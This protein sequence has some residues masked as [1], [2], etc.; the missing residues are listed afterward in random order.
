M[1]LENKNQGY[2]SIY[3]SLQDKSWYSNPDYLALWIHLLLSA[4]HKD[5]FSGDTLIKRGQLKT[6]RKQLA[7]KTGINESK[8]ERILK[9]FEESEQQIEQQKTNKFRL[10]T[11]NNFD[12][13]QNVNSKVNNTAQ[14]SNSKTTTKNTNNN[15]NKDNNSNKKDISKKESKT[16]FGYY[17]K[18]KLTNEEYDR[19]L[20]DYG[21]NLLETMIQRLDEYNEMKGDKYKSH[22]A[23]IRNW[24]KR[25]KLETKSDRKECNFCRAN[26]GYI[27]NGGQQIKCPHGDTKEEIKQKLGL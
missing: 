14:Q 23:V 2:I 19:L 10:I 25:D 9:F 26:N 11:I 22:N 27:V 6:G 21:H 8:I 24:I 18:V 1:D 5:R 20:K 3:R 4:N 12:E 16:K 7:E 17:Q 13:Y 15:V